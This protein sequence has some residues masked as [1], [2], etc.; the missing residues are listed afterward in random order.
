M[1]ASLTASIASLLHTLS[2]LTLATV[3]EQ[4]QPQAASLF[5][6]S[7]ADLHVYWVSGLNSRHSQNLA[8][9]PQVALTV[10]TTTWSWTEIAGVQMEGT[11]AVVPAGAAW[12]AAWDRYLLKF[13][14]VADFQAE[15]SRSNFYHFTPTWVRLVDNAQG[16]GH[17]DEIRFSSEAT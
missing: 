14:F 9:R 1:S 13:P 16:F 2:T 17:K 4:G 12:Q 3:N 11:V 6:V 15:V 5:F 8:H 10:H 7:D